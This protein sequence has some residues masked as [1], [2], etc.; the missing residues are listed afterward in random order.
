MESGQDLERC[1]RGIVYL[2]ES[3]KIRKS[4]GNVSISRDVSGEG[5]QHALLKIVEGNVINVPKVRAGL[6]LNRL[7]ALL[8]VVSYGK[9]L[10]LK[11]SCRCCRNRAERTHV[12]NFCRLIRPTFSLYAEGRFRD[13]NELLTREWTRHPLVLVPK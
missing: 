8:F 13:W 4:G 1:Q 11:C 3:D 5:V 2:D 7:R 9:I 10:T 12:G 6:F